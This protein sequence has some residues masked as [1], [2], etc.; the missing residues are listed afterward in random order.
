[1]A[2]VMEHWCNVAYGEAID[3]MP[4]EHVAVNISSQTT[5]YSGRLFYKD[6]SGKAIEGCATSAAFRKLLYVAQR[7]V[8]QP[9]V[10]GSHAV[11]TRLTGSVMGA[12][13]GEGVISGIPV[14]PGVQIQTTEYQAGPT[15]AIGDGVQCA[16]GSGEWRKST[17]ATDA[18]VRGYVA[19]AVASVNGLNV[20]TIN[21]VDGPAT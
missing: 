18:A 7:G 16:T 14:R 10:A 1:M 15:Y 9:D 8:D 19:A 3:N 20:L 11:W 13:A 4:R 5:L 21:L 6:S 17:A 12:T 2:V